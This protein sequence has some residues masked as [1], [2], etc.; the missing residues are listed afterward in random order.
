MGWTGFQCSSIKVSNG[1]VRRG[2]RIRMIPT[3]TGKKQTTECDQTPMDFNGL[4]SDQ[5]KVKTGRFGLE[6]SP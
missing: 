3:R 5:G 1:S 2:L 4:V 6:G